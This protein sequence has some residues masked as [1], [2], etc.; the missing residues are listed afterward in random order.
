MSVQITQLKKYL[1]YGQEWRR[2]CKKSTDKIK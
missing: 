2:A 1:C